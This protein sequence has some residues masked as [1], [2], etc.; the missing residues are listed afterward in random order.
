MD[1][2]IDTLDRLIDAVDRERD[3]YIDGRT[4]V[5]KDRNEEDETWT[6]KRPEK[7]TAVSLTM[8]C[9]QS[10]VVGHRSPVTGHHLLFPSSSGE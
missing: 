3:R 4:L 7:M 2:N 8:T 10:S 9:Y 1:R 6:S 5:R